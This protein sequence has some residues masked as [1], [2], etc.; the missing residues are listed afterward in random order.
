MS[1]PKAPSLP[2]VPEFFQDPLVNQTNQS[3]YN[4]GQGLISGSIFDQVPY[5]KDTISFNPDITALT[6]QSLRSQLDPQLNQ[7]RQDII[8]QLEANNQL[9]GS[10]TASALTNLQS[11]YENR[12][13]GAG[14]EAGIADINRAL[15]NRVGLFGTG[16]NTLQ[17][18]GQG[19]FQN[20][21]QIN[22]FNL[23]NYQNQVAKSLAEQK[24]KSG[25]LV[26]ALT[27]GLGGAALG[28]AAA[29]FTGGLSLG[30]TGA[31]AAGGAAAGG[32][33]PSGTGGSLF[34]AG[35]GALGGGLGGAR[36]ASSGSSN[37]LTNSSI[38]GGESIST[39]LT[40]A[41]GKQGGLFANFY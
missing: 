30:L 7:S 9:T 36:L 41:L 5:L 15:Q 1:K 22:Q 27:G 21:S 11:D 12:L 17:A 31:L 10:T 8:N 26:G 19:A 29:P 35:A 3:L 39:P 40:G 20:Q 38:F 4:T 6:L 18:A 13:I 28:I 2:A 24:Q 33:G 23:E 37:V 32:F 34:N 25:G 14:A 16:L